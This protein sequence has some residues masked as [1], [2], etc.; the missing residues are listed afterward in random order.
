MARK[1]PRSAVGDFLRFACG[2]LLLLIDIIIAFI[3][4]SL[5]HLIGIVILR[6]PKITR[7]LKNSVATLYYCHFNIAAERIAGVEHVFS[8]DK[9]PPGENVIVICN[10]IG[11]FDFAYLFSITEKKGMVGF[12]KFFS[13]DEIK[14]YPFWGWGMMLLDYIWVKR[15]WTEDNT[16]IRETFAKQLDNPDEPIGIFIFPEGRRLTPSRLAEAQKFAQEKHLPVLKNVLYPRVKGFRAS[17]K[18]LES[19]VDAVYDVTLGYPKRDFPSVYTYLSGSYSDSLHMHVRRIPLSHFKN[20][21]ED[22]VSTWLYNTWKEKDQL[23]EYFY[24]HG[25]FPGARVREPL[26]S[27]TL[28]R[29][30]VV[31]CFTKVREMKSKSSKAE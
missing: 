2:G 24:E 15:D 13:K 16:R 14:K 29:E 22:D 10:H 6:Q 23:L 12:S 3:A 30:N 28:V 5:L 11:L 19:M 25:E 31:N 4:F 20:M 9:L 17:V 18:A 26:I 1:N 27:V 21:S 7:R 8:G